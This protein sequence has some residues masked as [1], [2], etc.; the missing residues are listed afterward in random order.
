MTTL[1]GIANCDTVKKAQRWLQTN[2]VA[3]SFHDFRKDGLTEQQLNVW[4]EQLG[5]EVLL[6]KRSTSWRQLDDEVKNNID[7]ASA[8][9]EMLAT[10]TLIKRP[11]LVQND[12]YKVGFKEN[13]YS[14]L[15][16][17]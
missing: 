13:E 16:S 4:I 11:V 14:A 8:I 15:F 1:Y 7:Q 17:D 9:R 6:N 5:W 3:F 2:N 10:P 12:S